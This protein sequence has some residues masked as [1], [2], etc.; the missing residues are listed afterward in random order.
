MNVT[1]RL[2][3]AEIARTEWYRRSRS[4]PYT[5]CRHR[6]CTLSK[7]AYGIIGIKTWIFKGE[8]MDTTQ[9]S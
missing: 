9:G 5:A 4:A 1:G 7:T 8:I 3:G 2:G 6:L